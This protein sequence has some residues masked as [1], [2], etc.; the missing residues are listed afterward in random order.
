MPQKKFLKDILLRE[1]FITPSKLEAAIEEQRKTG[2]D[3]SKI[4]VKMKFIEEDQLTVALS[5]SLQIPLL[6]LSR[7]KIDP[8]L[9][10]IIPEQ[11]A[12]KY[13]VL[14]VAKVGDQLSLA[15]VDPLDLL[16]MDYVSITTGMKPRPFLVYSHDL[17][18]A[19]DVVY[20][21]E[22]H[23][24]SDDSFDDIIKDIQHGDDVELVDAV[25]AT[26]EEE[27]ENLSQD[28]PI[29][30]LTNMIIKQSVVS[31]ASDVFIE[32]MENN[33]RI[34]YR[35]DGMLREI[36]RMSK[37]LHFP[38]VSR[39]KVISNLDISEHRLPQ[40][41]RFR[42][43]IDEKEVD[44]RV[45]VLPTALGEKIVLRVLDKNLDRIDVDKLGFQASS[46]ER[47]KECCAR[48]HGMILACGPTGSGKTTTLYSILR[49]IDSPGKNLVTVEDPVEYQMRGLNQVNIRSEVGLTFASALRSILRQ[50]PD[51]IMIGE[52]RDTETLNIGVKA[53]LT[54]H[55]VLSSLHTTTAAGSIIR[56][57]NMGVEPFL[58]CSSVLCIVAQRL[59]RR[60]CPHCSEMYEASDALYEKL[61]IANVLHNK[62]DRKFVRGRGCD[63]CLETGYGGRVGITEILVLT[64][65][66]K[67]AILMGKGEIELKRLAREEGM[68]TMRE[69]GLSKAD[70]GLTTLEEVVRVTAPDETIKKDLQ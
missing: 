68:I 22:E 66:M 10:K 32:P 4:L 55:L 43:I 30:R 42:T 12:R 47:L 49:H 64:P 69:D 2:G 13:G 38:I 44:F 62:T 14:P 6:H 26:K 70:E 60:V 51:V 24:V 59:L 35:I 7:M 58:L 27:I 37:M 56:M 52:I 9:Q 25:E 23:A 48:P 57:I 63:L 8:A 53:A 46:L 50:D 19:I 21:D 39:I 11:S 17:Y 65:K 45:S 34:R 31:K 1:K 20:S 36:D 18:E 61:N 16:A 33:L 67:E 5:E 3:L 41:G 54:G 40:D 28:A 29:I 15:M